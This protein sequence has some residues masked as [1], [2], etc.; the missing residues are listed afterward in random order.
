MKTRH[1]YVDYNGT[2]LSGAL[3]VSH[4]NRALQYGDGIF[5]TM[6]YHQGRVLFEADHF[7]R[8]EAGIEALKMKYPAGLTNRKFKS[9]VDKLLTLNNIREDARIRLQ[10]TRNEGGFYRPLSSESSYILTV[11]S[12][13]EPGFVLSA[14]GLKTDV[15]D[16]VV[17]PLNGLSNQKTC[18]ALPYVL[19]GIYAS[20]NKLDDCL[21]RNATGR[22]AEATASNVFIVRRG[23]IF[24]P[25]LSEGCV[26]G[27]MRKNILAHS[28]ELNFGIKEKP[29]TT[30]DLLAADEIFL[31]NVITG[32][33]W[34]ETFRQKKLKNDLTA[35]LSWE[36]GQSLSLFH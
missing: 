29:L 17:L 15:C 35:I 16:T 34:V 31:T 20:E 26:A 18:N 30:R 7:A 22:I 12:L 27:V 21:L 11:S 2:I 8:L 28:A 6:H 36:I 32:I 14:R 3:P 25:P 5:E 24:T 19:A 10:V 1:P 33:R 23:N 13:E 9:H 4:A